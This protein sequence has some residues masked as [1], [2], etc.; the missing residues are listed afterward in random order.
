VSGGVDVHVRRA[1]A[2]VVVVVVC[3]C[4]GVGM[5]GVCD[6]GWWSVVCGGVGWWRGEW[7]GEDVC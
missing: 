5:S 7:K 6:K 3:V 1:G 4:V 2:V